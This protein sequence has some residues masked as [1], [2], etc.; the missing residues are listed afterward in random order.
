MKPHSVPYASQDAIEKELERLEKLGVIEKVNHS[1]WATPIVPVL[2]PD[3]STR[4][5]SDYKVTINPQISVDQYPLAKVDDLLAD[6]AGGKE[7]TKLD[8]T[9]AYQ[10]VLLEP[11]SQKYVTINTHRGLY[12]YKRMPF[13]IASAPA[14]FQQIMEKVLQGIPKVIFYLDDVL[15]TGCNREEH[16]QNLKQVLER[17]ESP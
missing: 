13:G 12:R 6:L 17:L 4:I 16:L 9:H 5:C 2:K 11:E 14:V 10:Q 15:V 8:L 7:F 1:E 3:G